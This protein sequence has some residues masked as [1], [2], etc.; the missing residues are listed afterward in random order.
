ML[1]MYK[2]SIC[3]F[4]GFIILSSCQ[5]DSSAVF[6]VNPTV[7][8]LYEIYNEDNTKTAPAN[9]LLLEI[10]KV[11]AD[12][13]LEENKRVGLMEKGLE[14]SKR[15]HIS[16]RSISFLYPLIRDY[17]NHADTKDRMFSLTDIMFFAK[18][19]P[20]ANVLASGILKN[21]DGDS[22]NEKLKEK[23]TLAGKDVDSYITSLAEKIFERPDLNGLNRTAS[24]EYIDACQAY[25][26]A[27]PN[28]KAAPEYLYKAAE[29]AKSIRS[30]TKALSLYDWVLD[31]FPNYEKT[32]TTLFIKGFIL[33]NELKN[34]DMAK[35]VY[36][37]F[38]EKFPND[39]LADDVKF[40]L[41][42]IGKSDAE[43]SKII[44][45]KKQEG[46]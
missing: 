26:L 18:K 41:D 42:N 13:E 21:Y 37:Q 3:L 23:M 6:D 40:L 2:F 32:P 38:L 20:A 24:I 8:K 33:E 25:A 44:E 5:T 22:R 9:N 7:A 1:K 29:V 39:D 35:T 30:I 10:N 17:P 28:S 34:I 31:K 43:I 36:N 12:P 27:F 16:A 45:G 19:L 4:V 14:I 15:H 46:K 11:L